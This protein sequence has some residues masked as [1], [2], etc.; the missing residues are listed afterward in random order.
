MINFNGEVWR[1][2]LVS[3]NHPILQ[4]SNGSWTIGA[5]DNNLKS[6]YVSKGLTEFMTRRVL[7]HELTHAAMFSYGVEL[8]FDQEELF[9]DL[10]ATYGREIICK[11]NMFFSRIKEKEETFC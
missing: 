7:S 1:V 9:A 8:T 2:L 3:P 10:I 5:C 6:I 4:R 11:T